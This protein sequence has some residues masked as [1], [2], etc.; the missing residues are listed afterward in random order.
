MYEI[1]DAEVRAVEKVIRSGRLMRDFGGQGTLSERFEERLAGLVGTKYALAVN[2]GTSALICA[3]VGAGVGPG[4][5]VIV[6]G[7][8]FIATALAPLAVGAVP[9]VAEVDETLVMD[10]ADVEKKISKYTRAILPVHM[11]GRPCNM[12]AI[13]RVARRHKVAVVEDACQ[14]VGGSFRGKRL[15]SLGDVGVF[16]FNWYK[17]ISAGEGGAVMTSRRRIFERAMIY[18]DGGLQLYTH[19]GPMVEPVFAGVKLKFT[20]IQAA[21]MLEQLKRLDKI[22]ARLRKRAAA[23]REVFARTDHI[24]PNPDNDTEGTCGT[25]LPV[26][27][28]TAE[29]ALALGARAKKLGLG[30]VRPYDTGKH[31]YWDWEAMFQ[32]R[33]S[34]ADGLNPFGMARRKIEYST[35]MCPNTR[36]I[37]AR[38]VNLGVPYKATLAEVRRLAR[39]L[40]G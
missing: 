1:G 29:E 25:V 11:I 12:T 18:A 15:G 20:E 9:V 27:L 39:Q 23:M 2:S 37:L 40:A 5:E 38:T 28:P 32:H 35:D 4:D 24:V 33:G 6:P 30:G 26:I 17:I 16:S 34:H 14:A 8:T 36:D 10:P 31:V 22:L 7:Y 21:I 19:A 3:L 13:N